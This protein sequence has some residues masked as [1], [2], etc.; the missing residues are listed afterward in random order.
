M[1]V[2]TGVYG[3]F[4]SSVYLTLKGKNLGNVL[5]KYIDFTFNSKLLV[6]FKVLVFQNVTEASA[7]AK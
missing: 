5:G 2:A 4:H 3:L 7:N 1:F 6:N